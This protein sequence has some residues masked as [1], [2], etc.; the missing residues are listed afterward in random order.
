LGVIIEFSLSYVNSS[1]KDDS[2]SKLQ[3]VTKLN[4]FGN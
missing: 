1:S 2:V 4:L 3:S